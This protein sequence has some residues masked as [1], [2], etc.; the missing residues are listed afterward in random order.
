MAH[1][2]LLGVLVLGELLCFGIDTT[3]DEQ[4]LLFVSNYPRNI[5]V[6]LV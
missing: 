4:T 6:V 1:R 3:A 5:K 2:L